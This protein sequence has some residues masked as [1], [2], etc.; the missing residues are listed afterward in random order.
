MASKSE[1]RST[2]GGSTRCPRHSRSPD[3]RIQP[4]PAVRGPRLQAQ[5]WAVW[6]VWCWSSAMNCHLKV[7]PWITTT[8][9]CPLPASVCWRTMP[10]SAL[11]RRRPPVRLCGRRAA[12]PVSR[13]GDAASLPTARPPRDRPAS[14]SRR[15]SGRPHRR[16]FPYRASE[17]RDRPEPDH[18]PRRIDAQRARSS[19]RCR[20][21]MR[22]RLRAPASEA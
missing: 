6:Q 1:S 2:R 13:Q 8:G 7:T 10:G 21:V 5:M 3:N 16:R 11:A 12:G 9:R 22:L 18:R 15:W 14:C 20:V 4:S 17:T 19:V